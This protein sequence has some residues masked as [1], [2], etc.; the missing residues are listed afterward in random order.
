MAEKLLKATLN[1]LSV[2][3]LKVHYYPFSTYKAIYGALH[4]ASD[5]SVITESDRP[6]SGMTTL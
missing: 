5:S 1:L 6:P 3:N 2:N 4:C